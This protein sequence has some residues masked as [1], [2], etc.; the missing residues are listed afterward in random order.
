MALDLIIR[1]GRVYDGLGNE[2]R[3]ADVGIKDGRISEVGKISTAAVDALD[4]DGAIVTPGYVDVHTHYDG[5]AT[6]SSQI[7]PSNEHGVTTVVM[8]NCGVGFAPCRNTDHARLIELMEGVEDIPGA[9]LD[10]GLPWQWESFPEY[11]DYL[12]QHSYDMDIAAQLPH[13]ALRV[14]VMGERG[15]CK[16][17]ANEQDIRQMRDITAQAIRAGA[18]GFSS[19]RTINHRSSKGEHIPSLKA[20]SDELL[21]IAHGLKDAGT[22]VIEM[23]SDFEELDEE[24]EIFRKMVSISGRP[25][26]ISLAQGLSP[27]GWKKT[28]AK[29]EEANR[30]GLTM[31]G[32]VAP[33]AIG[34]LLG[35][36]TTLNPFTS[37]PSYEEVAKLPLAEKIKA[38]KDPTR[39]KRILNE[40]PSSG[41]QRLFL[42]MAGGKRLWDLGDPPNYEPAPEDSLFAAA[43][44]AGIEP[45]SYIYDKLLE[46]EGK[47]LLYSPFANYADDN[48]DC[49]RE[50]ILHDNTIMGLGDGGAHVGTICDASFTTTLLSHWGRDR[51]RG[52]PIN[53]GFLVKRQT[54]DNARAMGLMDRGTLEP[55]MRADLNVIDFEN[56]QSHAPRIVNDLPLGGPRLTQSSTGY[57]ATVVNGVITRAKGE[58][59]GKLPGRLIRGK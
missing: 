46:N 28:L 19:S 31:T 40:T 4:A 27:H 43:E 22:G 58:A 5:L 30:D 48:L 2:P 18:I 36:I 51:S 1:G 35:N 38:L 20:E 45:W 21:G 59:T 13:A 16:E 37:R 9:A 24:F 29:L 26:S 50:M 54:R 14:Y 34:I 52:E 6:W 39:K 12:D 41:F 33:R 44:A 49:C 3:T 25:M 42:S 8:G 15:V 57:L 32:Q 53:L 11:L 7:S 56:L 10:E 17:A 55:G 47:T 23:I